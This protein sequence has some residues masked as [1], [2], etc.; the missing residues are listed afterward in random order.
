MNIGIVPVGTRSVQLTTI[1]V[2][3][4]KSYCDFY[5][6]DD[7]SESQMSIVEQKMLA[8]AAAIDPVSGMA[9][10]TADATTHAALSD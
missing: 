9:M 1:S 5:T 2:A 8:G 4:S 3:S 7:L 10:V 6:V